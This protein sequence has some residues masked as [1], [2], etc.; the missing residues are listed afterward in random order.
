MTDAITPPLPRELRRFLAAEP[1][2]TSGVQAL[3][4]PAKVGV[5]DLELAVDAHGRTGLRRRYVK[6]PMSLSRPLHI[7][8]ARPGQAFVYL[9]ATGGGLAEN[10]RVHQR[11]HLSEGAQATVT[12]QA[13][14]NV[15]R[16]N[17]G[18]A[19]L[20]T[21]LRVAEGASLEYAPGHTTLFGGSRL[22][23]QTDVTLAESATYIGSEVLMLGRIARGEINRFDAFTQGM[24][25]RRDGSGVL[26]SDTLSVI[27]S[28]QASAVHL[29]G[30]WP[31]WAT[32]LIVPPRERVSEIP[33]LARTVRERLGAETTFG[34]STMVGEEGLVVRIAGSRREPV[35]TAADSAHGLAR[36]LLLNAPF[37]DL[38]RMS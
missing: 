17:A 8:R 25:I 22:A 27:D 26:L 23:Q 20:W 34:V 18:L 5:L 4:R 32:V 3:G 37:V 38:R 15:H 33:A 36:E 31:V 28:Q 14:T 19:T 6:A 12:T 35:Q 9:R 21:Q 29:F 24:R 16:M 1:P 30:E 7:D 13:A 2:V 10:D 11:I